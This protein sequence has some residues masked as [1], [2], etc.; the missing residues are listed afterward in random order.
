MKGSRNRGFANRSPRGGGPQSGLLAAAG[1]LL[2]LAIPDAALACGVCYGDPDAPMT[3]GLN[4]GILV[5][6]GF[7]GVV[8]AGF[9]AL[10]WNFRKR[11]KDAQARRD[12]FEL[13]RGGK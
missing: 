12:G 7:V 13:I 4:K 5:L 9:V 3:D 2:L 1:L 11:A 10:F 8:Q 6:L